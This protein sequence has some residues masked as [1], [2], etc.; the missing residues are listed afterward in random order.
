MAVNVPLLRKAVEWAESE[1]VKPFEQCEWNQGQWITAPLTRAHTIA[2]DECFQKFGDPGS[3]V[4]SPKEARE[5]Y[6][7][8]VGELRH[9]CGTAFCI[10]GYIGQMI[11]ERYAAHDEVDGCHVGDFAQQALGIS[12]NEADELF[13]AGNSIEDVRRIADWIAGEAL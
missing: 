2:N 7:Q 8:R 1:A 5:F 13:F 9:T 3:S 10:A 11:D 4:F 12:A 6:T